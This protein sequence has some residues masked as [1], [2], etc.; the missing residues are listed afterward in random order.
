[1]RSWE[2]VIEGRLREDIRILKNQFGFMQG[3]PAIE[4]IHLVHRPVES[5]GIKKGTATWCLLT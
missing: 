3:R 5:T 2:R 4:A 1:M